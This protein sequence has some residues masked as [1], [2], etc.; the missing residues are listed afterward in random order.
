[1]VCIILALIFF[2]T[3]SLIATASRM[4]W[5]F[6]RDDGLPGSNWFSKVRLPSSCKSIP[7]FAESS[8]NVFLRLGRTSLGSAS[9]L[10]R[11]HSH[12]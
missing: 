2:A 1:M 11:Y 6:A 12:H 10:Y 5:A 4:T 7:I 9:L 3:I 8:L